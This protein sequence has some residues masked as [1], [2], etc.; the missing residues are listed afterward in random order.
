MTQSIEIKRSSAARDAEDKSTLEPFIL[1][2]Q[3][4]QIATYRPGWRWS[5]DVK[6]FVHTDS[7]QYEHL[8]FAASGQM[9]VIGEDGA[10][11]DVN[12]GDIVHLQPGHDA[13]VVGD[14]PAIWFHVLGAAPK[15]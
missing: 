10:E 5:T 13:W 6:P 4:V 2:D 15:E 8:A 1:G 7:C 12:P 11:A 9:H 3:N 14:E